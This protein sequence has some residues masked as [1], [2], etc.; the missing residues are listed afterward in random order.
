MEFSITSI[1]YKL[2]MLLWN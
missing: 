2:E 1:D